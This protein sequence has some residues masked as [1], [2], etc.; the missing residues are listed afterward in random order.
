MSY[1]WASD[2]AGLGVATALFG[3]LTDGGNAV[4]AGRVLAMWPALSQYVDGAIAAAMAAELQGRMLPMDREEWLELMGALRAV[5]GSRRFRSSIRNAESL[6]AEL[7]ASGA[8]LPTPTTVYL[9]L[10]GSVPDE[11]R[12]RGR[13]S[14]APSAVGE[15]PPPPAEV[16]RL[17]A[18]A[19]V[20]IKISEEAVLAAAEEVQVAA[21]SEEAAGSA[22]GAAEVASAQ[23]A[24][25]VVA[26]SAVA[27]AELVAAREVADRSAEIA[28]AEPPPPAAP[29]AEKAEE[30]AAEE[31]AEPAKALKVDEAAGAEVPESQA[32]GR[33][34]EQEQVE[35]DTEPPPEAKPTVKMPTDPSTK[36]AVL[37]FFKAC[38]NRKIGPALVQLAED[39]KTP[40]QRAAEEAAARFM[41][42]A[43]KAEEA[44]KHLEGVR[45]AAEEAARRNKAATEA[46]EEATRKIQAD[47][48]KR[49]AEAR[50]RAEDDKKR[51]IEE[52]AKRK[53][54]AEEEARRREEMRRKEREDAR[55]R[56]E[57]ERRAIAE[58][59]AAAE[60]RFNEMMR[61]E[62]QRLAAEKVMAEAAAAEARMAAERAEKVKK[63]ELKRLEEEK[64]KA[65]QRAQAVADALRRREQSIQ[66]AAG[67]AEKEK[68][69]LATILSGQLA[70][71]EERSQQA[72][73]QAER[74][75]E[76]LR[77]KLAEQMAAVDALSH[78]VHESQARGSAVADAIDSPP[79]VPTRPGGVAAD[80]DGSPAKFAAP[81][82]AAPTDES[83]LVKITLKV[84]AP[85]HVSGAETLICED[86]ESSSPFDLPLAVDRQLD[87]DMFTEDCATVESVPPFSPSLGSFARGLSKGESVA[88]S[89]PAAVQEASEHEEQAAGDSGAGPPP[90]PPPPPG[91]TAAAAGDEAPAK[92]ARPAS[93]ADSDE[94]LLPSQKAMNAR[95]RELSVEHQTQKAGSRAQSPCD[96]AKQ[97]LRAGLMDA[98]RDGSLKEKVERRTSPSRQADDE[99]GKSAPP[100]PPAMPSKPT[101]G[102]EEPDTAKSAPPPPPP[103]RPTREAPEAD[104]EMQKS[105]RGPPPAGDDD[106]GLSD[107]EVFEVHAGVVKIVSKPAYAQKR[108]SVA[109]PP[110]VAER[111]FS[112]WEASD[113]EEEEDGEKMSKQC[114]PM[115]AIQ[116]IKHEEATPGEAKPASL[117]PVVSIK[118]GKAVDEQ[119]QK[120]A[121]PPPPPTAPPKPEQ[122]EAA[123]AEELSAKQAPPPPPAAKP[124]Q[125]EET[126]IETAKSAQQ[127]AAPPP[128]PSMKPARQEEDSGYPLAA[129]S[130]AAPTET[131]KP[132]IAETGSFEKTTPKPQ[133]RP[134]SGPRQQEPAEERLPP[135]RQSYSTPVFIEPDRELQDEL[136]KEKE[137]HKRTALKLANI[138]KQLRQAV[139]TIDRQAKLDGGKKRFGVT[140]GTVYTNPP[141]MRAAPSPKSRQGMHL[142]A[143][144][145]LPPLDAGRPNSRAREESMAAREV[146]A[147][148]DQTRQQPMTRAER[149]AARIEAIKKL[150]AVAMNTWDLRQSEKV[151]KLRA[152]HSFSN[153][154]WGS[155]WDWQDE[156]GVVD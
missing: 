155:F 73:E 34:E 43:K 77:A 57:E 90:P 78:Q 142:P 148:L 47:Q 33:E 99:F 126:P 106:D 66:E 152:V 3:R 60:R 80:E 25:E 19:E 12:G 87:I 92:A 117:T 8:R 98:A 39:E 137:N 1:D 75:K 59:R 110:P 53:R 37:K 94:G 62:M 130:V 79:P 27:S 18:G 149:S 82:S 29:T 61:G 6:H 132:N 156:T 72:M 30:A 83:Q 153:A 101:A 93:H 7:K 104:G 23:V 86:N 84:A 127:A 63:A 56:A 10:P 51:I 58:A 81:P 145:S 20:S 150:D 68:E 44:T 133:P 45:Q 71:L 113:D 31:G 139:I 146:D 38:A 46:A 9:P 95:A 17:R 120:S 52:N 16:A 74:E 11:E 69:Q 116:V 135:L 15:E 24:S 124:E 96:P 76:E 35:E 118:V 100:A 42:Q 121:P 108:A 140:G 129:K 48:A 91:R 49:E 154:M 67:D 112:A 122:E 136:K 103:G 147:I 65:E 115:A 151:S 107:E 5:T 2:P 64:Q 89:I 119:S 105:V 41:E 70:E 14:S 36:S 144:R 32:L 50:Q 138:E 123:A 102:M 114:L 109:A 26:N 134:K 21:V 28:A 85:S 13:R 141:P 97:L 111:D 143:L 131:K 55:R 88:K 40:A 4:D 128:P 125:R 54:E 22:P